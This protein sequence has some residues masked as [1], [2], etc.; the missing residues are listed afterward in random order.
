MHAMRQSCRP[1]HQVLI[2]K[3]YP[4]FQK[5]VVD[6]KPNSSELSYLLY[7]ASTRRS[8]LQKVGEFLERRTTSDVSKGRIGY[9]N[10]TPYPIRCLG[11]CAQR[12]LTH[13]L[14]WNSNIQVTLQILKAIIE[15]LP[16]DL[17]LYAQYVL[18]ILSAVLRS[19]DLA[20]T[21]DTLLTFETFCQHHDVATLA[22]NQDHVEHYEEIV[23]IYASFADQNSTSSS[24]G[25]LSAPMAIRWRSA[26][27]RALQS[28]TASEAV[29]ADG[30]RQLN[31]IIPTILQNLHPEN[32]DYL[33]IL[34]QRANASVSVDKETVRRR[35]SIATVRTSEANTKPHSAT[36]SGT[37][38]DADRLAE[39]E[40]ALQALKSLEQIFVTNNRAQIR[41]ATSSMLGFICTKV[42]YQ[43]QHMSRKSKSRST[44]S[45]ATALIE[46]VAK[47]APVQDR[48]VILVTIVETLIRAPIV[49]ESLENQLLLISLIGWLLRSDLNMIGLSV[50]DVLLG[51]VQH[52]LLLLRLGGKGSNIL[53]HH[54][55]TDAIDLFQ[56]ADIIGFLPANDHTEKLTTEPEMA[57]PSTNRQ[58]LLI[59]VQRC[60]GDLANHIYYSDQIS[61]ILTA[62]L[63]RL[64]PSPTSG[65]S[66]DTAAVENPHA[67]ARAISTSVN[68]QENPNTDEFFSFGTARV[69]ALKAIK[70]VLVVANLKGSPGTA[71]IGRNRVG[72]HVWEGT[73]WLLRDEDRRVR[74][75]YVDALLT[76]LNLE[77]SKNDLRVIDDR[78][79]DFKAPSRPNGESSSW[80]HLT[81]RAVSNASHREKSSKPA[82]STFLQ[83]L[84]L[85]IYNSAIESPD[86]ETDLLLLHLLL[87]RLIQKLGV[88]AVKNG[89]P[90]IIR[91]QEDI[92][93]DQMIATPTAKL[94]VGSL[95][96]G[97]FWALSEKFDF[98]SSKIGF[99]IHDEIRRRRTYGLWLNAIQL[100]PIPIDQIVLAT[101]LPLNEKPPLPILQRESLRPFDSCPAMVCQIAESY[102]ASLVSPPTSPPN[103]PSRAFSMPIL[104]NT[105]PSSASGKELPPA[106][107][108]AMLSEWSK[109]SCIANIEKE[110]SRTVSL[111]GSRTISA[112]QKYLGING[113]NGHNGYP[114]RNGSPTGAHSPIRAS[115][116]NND[117]NGLIQNNSLTFS[118][119]DPLETRI[120]RSST[121]HS[122]SPTALSSSDQHQPLRVDDLKRVLAGGNYN[123]DRGASPLRNTTSRRDFVDTADQ[124]SISTGSESAISAVGFESVSEGDL[125]RSSPPNQRQDINRLITTSDQPMTRPRSINSRPQSVSSRPQSISSRPQSMHNFDPSRPTTRG[126][127]RPSSSSSSANEDPTAN[128]KA[129]RGDLV[130]SHVTTS[131][132]IGD[133]DVP[134]V[135]PLPAGVIPQKNIAVGIVPGEIQTEHLAISEKG[136]TMS[137]LKKKRGVDVSALLGS[138]DAITGEKGIGIGRG[139]PPY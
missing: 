26:G 69:T 48:F 8:K 109:D 76:W 37:A 50:I 20:V 71:A 126:T 31:I 35:M 123:N 13:V 100:P 19:K 131:N 34:Q 28:I 93:I 2:L 42:P 49:E 21:E 12:R 72:V 29:G 89:L 125:S 1:K 132:E 30:G 75:A 14:N 129:L 78:R 83:L 68:L 59:R 133:D 52:I 102:T 106:M 54:Q 11:M 22:A 114:T 56:D 104:S 7:Y 27:L 65:V 86:S 139:K 23:R 45:W 122:G 74:R 82:K 55:Q 105:K 96:H 4:K 115:P 3:C 80:G 98:E 57:P 51:L 87:V 17:P 111:N 116:L 101:T 63:L 38:D 9:V 5:N 128:A 64:K 137:H 81:R 124:R 43:S 110:N 33:A 95:V 119:Q 135:P 40:V 118:L 79:K 36:I 18:R 134:P 10:S 70:E 6:V 67:A 25:V 90:M 94:N 73:Q 61:D 32:E 58:E 108:E 44:G 60:I 113:H 66:S 91:L 103:S 15:K 46:M 62:I 84:H 41:I 85:A 138:I 117:S 97:Y 53:P 39:E 77:M 120:K 136:G 107:R 130:T 112:R 127:L 99:E 92:N 47:W 88:N 16:R 24:K 121:H